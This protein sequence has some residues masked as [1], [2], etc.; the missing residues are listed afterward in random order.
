MRKTESHCSLRP[1]ICVEKPVESRSQSLESIPKPPKKKKRP[2]SKSAKS[3]RIQKT[4]RPLHIFLPRRRATAWL[5]ACRSDT[6]RLN[7]C[8]KP[9]SNR[10]RDRRGNSHIIR[11]VHSDLTAGTDLLK[12]VRKDR[13][14][15]DIRQ[16]SGLISPPQRTAVQGTRYSSAAAARPRRAVV[17]RCSVATF[18]VL[19][20]VTREALSQAQSVE[21]AAALGLDEAVA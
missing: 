19:R 13:V 1:L 14:D 15:R 3:D 2:T 18:S 16:V 7:A 5:L 11:V 20:T 17:D 10:F 9:L 21:S 4:S 8:G 6:K 12:S